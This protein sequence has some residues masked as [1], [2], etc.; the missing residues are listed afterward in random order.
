MLQ[1][2]EGAIPDTETASKVYSIS[3]VYDEEICVA[4]LVQS[5]AQGTCSKNIPSPL[6]D[7]AILPHGQPDS[8]QP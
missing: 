2:D 6:C 7:G 8:S 5:M 4:G 1:R 3:T